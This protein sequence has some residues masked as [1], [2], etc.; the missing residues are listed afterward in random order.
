[1][2]QDGTGCIHLC[3]LILGKLKTGKKKNQF[4][5]TRCYS[6]ELTYMRDVLVLTIRRWSLKR[7]ARGES[8]L[9]IYLTFRKDLFR[10]RCHRGRAVRGG[11]YVVSTTH[12]HLGA[13]TKVSS[14]TVLSSVAVQI[15]T[16]HVS[17]KFPV[18]ARLVT[19]DLVPE[20]F[21]PTFENSI[22]VSH[23]QKESKT[24]HQQS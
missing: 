2:D 3:A 12:V 14:T 23:Q 18:W 5:Q 11:G 20:G 22:Q 24:Y 13:R 6:G 1:M 19:L 7:G 10:H 21:R 9:M 15:R 17:T 8:V 4:L 16:G